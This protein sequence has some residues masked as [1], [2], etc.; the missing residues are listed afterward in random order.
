MGVKL[1]S[2]ITVDSR[3]GVKKDASVVE[4]C[5]MGAILFPTDCRPIFAAF[6]PGQLPRP[7]RWRRE[8]DNH[9]S[10]PEEGHLDGGRVSS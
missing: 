1:F 7:W 9:S 4:L 6:E 8:F 10:L 5:L 2:F 3:A